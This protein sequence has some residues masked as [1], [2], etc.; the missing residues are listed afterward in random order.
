MKRVPWSCENQQ[1]LPRLR[2]NR[3]LVS[4]QQRINF[5]SV[6]SSA[7]QQGV[8]RGVDDG[9]R[10]PMVG[11]LPRRRRNRP[12]LSPQV[13]KNRAAVDV[14]GDHVQTGRGYRHTPDLRQVLA[15]Q[16]RAGRQL[17]V[18]LVDPVAHRRQQRVPGHAQVAPAIRGAQEVREAVVRHYWSGRGVVVSGRLLECGRWRD[19]C[20]VVAH[21]NSRLALGSIPSLSM[22]LAYC[23]F[24]LA[25]P[26]ARRSSPA[27]AA[28]AAACVTPP[29]VS[30][31]QETTGMET[32]PPTVR[33]KHSSPPP[34]PPPPPKFSLT[35]HRRVN[36]PK[37][38]PIPPSP[39]IPEKRTG[40]RC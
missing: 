23:T 39:Q 5:F 22:P 29:S 10:H 12:A 20:G 28:R 21:A 30:Y 26:R 35:R 31:Q 18:H 14:K 36:P 11:A 1:R 13:D 17:K 6:S 25:S 40:V 4:S 16:R 9:A 34:S 38:V 15:R 2:R 24:A 7:I 3:R 37:S 8:E 19:P 33:G 27:A 32:H